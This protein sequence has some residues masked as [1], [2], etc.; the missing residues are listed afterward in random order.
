MR[1]VST[2]V[3]ATDLSSRV[4]VLALNMEFIARTDLSYHAIALAPDFLIS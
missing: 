2:V 3:S 4:V 1:K